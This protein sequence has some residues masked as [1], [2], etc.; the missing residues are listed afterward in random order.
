MPDPPI[1]RPQARWAPAASAR[2]AMLGV[3]A[4]AVWGVTVATP[5]I[6]SHS[7]SLLGKGL[8]ADLAERAARAE[9]AARAA[10]E[11]VRREKIAELGAPTLTDPTG[12]IGQE[13]TPLVT[14]LGSLEAKRLSTS[15]AWA[16]ALTERLAAHGVGP[17]TVVAASLSGSFP[18]LNIALASAC[19][20]LDARLLAV[21]SV[22]AS[23]WGA[24]EPGFTWPEMEAR[25][26][27]AGVIRRVSIAVTAGGAADR[28]FD[29]AD[30]DRA[31]AERIRD[32]AA[33]RLDVPTLRPGNYDEA[34][35]VRVR[36]Y[37]RAAAGSPIVL[38]ANVGGAEASMGH[39]SAILGVGT[40][41]VSG[42]G[43][44]GRAG[45]GVTARF[46]RERV[47]ILMLLN[48]RELAVRWGLGL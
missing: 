17:G 10:Q 13:L 18:G 7:P 38:Y 14:T 39:S 35:E 44:E 42:A 29:L 27:R 26:V 11:V 45:G 24:N 2:L 23:T 22:T 47:P 25:L 6:P 15:P 33:A 41:F 28:A 31:L 32:A 40:G 43:L 34:V 16:R 30:E 12:L 36:A 3:V 1:F 9:A 48:V 8:I 19:G 5:P 37:R 20:A 4:A 21:S 46:A